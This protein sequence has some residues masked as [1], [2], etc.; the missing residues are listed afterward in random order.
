MLVT[1]QSDWYLDQCLSRR[2]E[3]SFSVGLFFVKQI[4][5]WEGLHLEIVFALGQGFHVT[6]QFFNEAGGIVVRTIFLTTSCLVRLILAFQVQYK[7]VCKRTCKQ[8]LTPTHA[9]VKVKC[10]VINFGD[11]FGDQNFGSGKSAQLCSTVC[12]VNKRMFSKRTETFVVPIV[13]EMIYFLAD[14]RYGKLRPD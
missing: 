10:L 9:A 5:Q 3:I 6:C 4:L 7:C 1:V 8:A 11:L 14:F 13:H 12:T 2:V